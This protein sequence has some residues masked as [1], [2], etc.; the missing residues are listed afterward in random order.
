M[1]KLVVR[2]LKPT[3]HLLNF[4]IKKLIEEVNGYW[5]AT[6][7]AYINTGRKLIQLDKELKKQKL[8]GGLVEKDLPWN[9]QY[10]KRMM[11][12]CKWEGLNDPRIKNRIPLVGSTIY[13]L[14]GLTKT[15]LNVALKEKCKRQDEH[16]KWYVDDLISPEV[17]R[18]EITTW[19]KNYNLLTAGKK[20]KKSNQSGMGKEV[21]VVIE[22]HKE[23]TKTHFTK[24]VNE[25]KKAVKGVKDTEF[26]CE[27]D[28]N[29]P[30]ST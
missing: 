3:K 14:S 10:A 4:K 30:S 1:T 18:E 8:S 25:L 9:W 11:K 12:A 21:T 19:R 7:S 26:K 17:K 24:K 6:W 20:V 27:L 13:T 5:G 28:A 23:I 15:Q 2:T 16:G 29:E 22:V